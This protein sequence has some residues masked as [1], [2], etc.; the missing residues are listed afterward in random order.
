M[1]ARDA[2][3]ALIEFT[4]FVA[5]DAVPVKLPVIVPVAIKTALRWPDF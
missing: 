1:A 2:L 4:A 3:V 5:K